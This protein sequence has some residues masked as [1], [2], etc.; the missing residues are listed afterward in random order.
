MIAHALSIA[1]GPLLVV[2]G[3]GGVSAQPATR[4]AGLQEVIL[5]FKTHYDIGYTASAH[6]V[7]ETYC[8]SMIDKALDVCDATRSPPA[9]QRFVWTIPGWPMMQ[10]LGPQQTPQRRERILA[11]L[12]EG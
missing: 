4:P 12:R 2:A 1:I 6:D 11:A 5:V 8:T 10:M 7:V 9:G 3:V